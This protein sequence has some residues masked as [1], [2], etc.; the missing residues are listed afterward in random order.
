MAASKKII[1]TETEIIELLNNLGDLAGA[2]S[3]FVS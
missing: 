1:S 3:D 2:S